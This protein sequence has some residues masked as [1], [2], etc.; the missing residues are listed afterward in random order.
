MSNLNEDYLKIDHLGQK[1]SKGYRKS[2]NSDLFISKCCF[3]NSKNPEL[4]QFLGDP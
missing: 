2:H 4:P 3:C 1:Y